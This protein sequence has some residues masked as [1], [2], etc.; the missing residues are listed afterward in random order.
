MAQWHYHLHLALTRRDSFKLSLCITLGHVL[1]GIMTFFQ[2][3]QSRHF[4]TVASDNEIPTDSKILSEVNRDNGTMKIS[5]GPGSPFAAEIRDLI[6]FWGK[7]KKQ[8]PCFLAVMTLEFY[9]KSTN[10]ENEA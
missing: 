3:C 7:G 9:E 6:N 5:G 1:A 4:V 10:R 8:I 2:A